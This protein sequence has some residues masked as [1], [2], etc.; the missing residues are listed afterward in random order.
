MFVQQGRHH[1]WRILADKLWRAVID[2]ASESPMP[3][4]EGVWHLLR[5]DRIERLMKEHSLAGAAWLQE[6]LLAD[7]REESAHVEVDMA[8]EYTKQV[9]IPQL[10]R[11]GDIRKEQGGEG[12]AGYYLEVLSVAQRIGSERHEE[13]VA[14]R[15]ALL[16]LSPG[17]LDL[18]Q[19]TYWLGYSAELCPPHD[20][21]GRAR[22]KLIEGMLAFALLQ[23]ASESE[24]AR[25]GHLR[26]TEEHFRSALYDLLPPEPSE[27]RAECELKFAQVIYAR[28]GSLTEAMQRLQSAIAWYDAD[29]NVYKA[30]CVRLEASRILSQAGERGRAYFYAREA[31]RGFAS[32]APHAEAEMLEANQVAGT[33]EVA[34]R[35]EEG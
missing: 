19:S 12:A 2:P 25:D 1:D 14:S 29:R 30:S 13:Q 15:L 27:E 31:E 7:V 24:D 22:L 20:R 33:L 11:M 3:G 17:A 18:K 16:Y 8:E 35:S 23:T 28:Q 5:N 9:L 26:A 32:L 10:V 6:R 4:R 21:L 34:G